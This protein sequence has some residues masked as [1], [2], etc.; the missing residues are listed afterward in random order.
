MTLAISAKLTTQ[1][2]GQATLA[3]TGAAGALPVGAAVYTSDFSAG[4]DSW[5]SGSDGA[6]AP[7]SLTRVIPGTA[8]LLRLGWSGTAETWQKAEQYFTRTITGLTIGNI[9]QASARFKVYGGIGSA[10]LV[11]VGVDGIGT[12]T[13]QP[14]TVSAWVTV[15]YTFTATAT[16]HAL[17]IRRTDGAFA[18]SVYAKD[19]TVQR[20]STATVAGISIQRTDANGT[21]FVRVV[22]GSVPDSSGA[23]TV[24]DEEFA[25]SGAVTY[26][27]V[28]SSGNQA[29]CT[30][31]NADLSASF[32]FAGNVLGPVG[33]LN[34]L[35]A[36]A[37]V[38]G[39]DEAYAYSENSTG[40]LAIIGRQDPIITSRADNQWS[41]RTGTLTYY[42]ASHAAAVLIA[43]EYQVGRIALLR[44]QGTIPDLYHVA[45]T[46]RVT[47]AHQLV[48]GWT[49]TVVVDYVETGWPSGDLQ[50]AHP[51]QY[52]DVASD[53]LAYYNL[54]VTFATYADL[55]AGP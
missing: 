14:V 1:D 39:Y 32:A 25:Q 18:W 40:K 12:G 11:D 36:V 31:T 29:S 13:P 19:I 2:C 55:L 3:V 21:R 49:W 24:Y 4:V 28:D 52:A 30:L 44:F 47:P 6:S 9:Y 41:K 23:Q 20:V 51:W 54:P 33:F 46:V 53:Y 50:G 22:S 37:R 5:T 7:P 15:T 27:V 10:V 43:A 45:N 26:A 42:A 35:L 38:D 48:G 34:Q 17:R 8:Y 16:S